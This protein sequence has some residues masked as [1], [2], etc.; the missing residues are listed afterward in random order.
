[1]T[2]LVINDLLLDE[3]LDRKA[4]ANVRGGMLYLRP[5]PPVAS[6]SR[7]IVTEIN[8]ILDALGGTWGSPDRDTR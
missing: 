8:Q 4:M 3:E 7:N 2:T 6:P 1:M 5:Y